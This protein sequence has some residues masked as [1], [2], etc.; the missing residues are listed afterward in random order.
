MKEKGITLIALIITIIVLLI[1]AAVSVAILTGDNGIINKAIE[2]REKTEIAEIIERAKVDILGVQA[3]NSGN[4]TNAQL[5]TI[6]AKYFNDVPE[7]LPE[8]LSTL[9]LTTKDEYGKHEIE[10]S[11]IYNKAIKPI[12]LA[13]DIAN[14]TD[15]SEYYGATVS[16]Y[17]CT[18]SAGV[19]AWKIFYADENN[20]YLIVDDYISYEYAPKGKGGTSLNQGDTNYKLYFTDVI[21]DYAGSSDITDTKIKALNNDYFN[22]KGYSSVENNMKAVAYMLDTNAWSVFA[23][24]KAE[25]AIG[26]PTIEMFMKSYSQKHNVDYKVQ[27]SSSMGYEIS[28]DEGNSWESWLR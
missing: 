26:G 14:S 22:V 27:A 10:I 2:A 6:L 8:D 16:G 7:T 13:R 11:K 18:N 23:G 5:Q 12:I 28:T 4:I 20:I 25:Y 3:G 19:N 17:T 15:K 21:S 1:L 9:L 24:N